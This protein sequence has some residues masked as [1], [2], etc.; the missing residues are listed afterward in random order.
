MRPGLKKYLSRAFALVL[1]LVFVAGAGEV[2]GMLGAPEVTSSVLASGA[3]PAP[4]N[5]TPTVR[6]SGNPIKVKGKVVEVKASS[7]AKKKIRIKRKKAMDVTNA[8]G[9]VTYKK[10]SGNDKILV[11][12]KTGEI[13]LKK[14]LKKGKYKIKVEVKASG[15]SGYYSK[16]AKATV[17]VKVVE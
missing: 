10:K 16:T 2:A 6:K 11:K 1:A 9:T 13:V 12:K 7:A 15:T 3:D 8:K 17:T 14:G 5:P 4:V